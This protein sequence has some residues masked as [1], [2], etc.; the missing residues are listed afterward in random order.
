MRPKHVETGMVE[1][2]AG[3][4]GRDPRRMTEAELNEI[5]HF[6]R[7]ILRAIRQNCIDCAGGSEAEVRRCRMAACPMWPY[8]MASNP[9]N[10]REMTDTQRAE[11]AE[12][13]RGARATRAALGADPA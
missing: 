5:G 7:P 8:R 4:I 3:E 13:L 9:F 2:E 6:K 11:A 10:S 12:R 1:G